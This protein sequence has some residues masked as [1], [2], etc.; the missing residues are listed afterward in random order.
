VTIVRV[1][2]D[3]TREELAETLALLNADAKAMSRRGKSAMLR[4][5]YE[6]AHKRINAVLTDYLAASS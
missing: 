4:P 1:T 5:E 6:R 3:T 2:E